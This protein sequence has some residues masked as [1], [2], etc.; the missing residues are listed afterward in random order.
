MIRPKVLVL[1][2][3]ANPDWISVP[4]VGWKHIQA[5]DTF[6]DSIVVTHERNRAGFEGP[7]SPPIGCALCRPV[8][9]KGLFMP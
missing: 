2:E 7:V 3:M 6:A 4:L 9:W 1:A 8:R 5:I